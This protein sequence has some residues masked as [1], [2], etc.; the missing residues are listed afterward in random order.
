M[1]A[2]LKSII[3][4]LTVLAVVV[5]TLLVLDAGNVVGVKK[6][7]TA[8]K[9]T[10]VDLSGNSIHNAS[11]TVCGQTFF[12]DDKG[13]SP[14]ITPNVLV[15]CYDGSITDWYTT[16]VAVTCDGCRRWCSTP[17]C[18][19]D[20]HVGLSSKCTP[21]TTASCRLFPTW[22]VRP[23]SMSKVYCVQASNKQSLPKLTLR[24]TSR[25]KY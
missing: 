3:V 20:K 15:N 23:T 18:L 21:W 8:I 19:T 6:S 5:G 17:C 22:K 4:A 1:K 11:V 7:I 10:A 24:Q 14:Q 25:C 2:T 13:C 12:T 9:V 16:T